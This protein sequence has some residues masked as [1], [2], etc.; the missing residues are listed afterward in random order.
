MSYLCPESQMLE[1]CKNTGLI[2]TATTY[3]GNL[4]RLSQKEPKSCEI[5]EYM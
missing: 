1:V 2:N 5:Q 4:S 3:S